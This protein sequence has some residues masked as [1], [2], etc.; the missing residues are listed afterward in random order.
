MISRIIATAVLLLLSG[1][2]CFAQ[3]TFATR[4]DGGVFLVVSVICL[5]LAVWNWFVWGMV[6]EGWNYGRG[7]G[8]DGPGLPVTAWFWPIYISS[9]FRMLGAPEPDRSAAAA[10]REQGSQR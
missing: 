4:S 5:G 10:R 7:S 9:V 1:S 8:K 2:A 6:R 3:A